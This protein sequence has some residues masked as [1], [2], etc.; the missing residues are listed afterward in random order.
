[1]G[2]IPPGE[3]AQLVERGDRTA[4]ARGSSPLFSIRLN[5]EKRSSYNISYTAMDI[6]NFLLYLMRSPSALDTAYLS[7]HKNEE[8]QHLAMVVAQGEGA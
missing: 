6:I 8:L 7:C 4:E 1:M 5:L 3:L 2:I